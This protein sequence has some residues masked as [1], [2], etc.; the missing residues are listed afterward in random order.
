MDGVYLAIA[1]GACLVTWAL[2]V[3]CAALM[4]DAEGE[5]P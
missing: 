2:L 3:L 1:A 4:G 5:K